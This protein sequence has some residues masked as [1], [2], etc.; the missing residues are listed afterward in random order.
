MKLTADQLEQLSGL[1]DTA[2]DL[3]QT[4]LEAWLGSLS[5][6]A[7]ALVPL[8]RDLLARRAARETGELLD[9]VPAFTVDAAVPASPQ[10]QAG[11]AVGPYRLQRELGRGGM[12]EVWLAERG[13]GQLKRAVA[14][15]LPIPNAR[16]SVLVQ[17]FAR[18]RDILGSLEHPHIARLYDA[19]FADDGQP[20]L[21]MEYVQGQ[22][23]DR[24]CKQ[25]LLGVPER[26]GLLLQVA[27]AV[28]FAHSRLVLHRDLKPSNILVTAEA[29][30]R[31]LD[32]GIAK[33]MQGETTRETELTLAAGRALTLDYA[34]P[35]QIRGAGIGTA[36][37][38]YS[39]GVVAFELLAG[40]RPYRLTRGSAAELEEA[41]TAQEPASASSMAETDALRKQLR[42]DI[43]AIL[44]KA[45]KKHPA[46]RYATIDALAQDWRR[47]LA[48][49]RVLARPDTWGLRLWRM[50][51]RHRL[52]LAAGALVVAAFVLGLGFGATALVM[53]ALVV[54]LAAALWQAGRARE[55]ARVARDESRR[56]QAVQGFLLDIFRANADTQ[57]DPAKAR[58]ATA[59]ELLDLGAQRL[60]TALHDTPQARAE[61]MATL[62]EMY[63][64]LG[65]D[66][67]AADLESQ[68]VELL[69]RLH[70]QDDRRVAQALV[71]LSFAL[72]TSS[73]RAEI[74]PALEEAKRILDAIGDRDSSL[75]GELLVRLAQ[76]NYSI[77]LSRS[78]AYAD[79]AVAVLR[80][81][82]DVG[83]DLHST[84]LGMSARV[85]Q[86]VG[87]L[88]VA[89]QLWRASIREIQGMPEVSQLQLVELRCSLADTLVLQLEVDA[90]LPIAREAV[91]TG[92]AAVGEADPV[93]LAARSRY[94]SVLHAAGQRVEARQEFE[95]SLQAILDIK[96]DADTFYTPDARLRY[97]RSLLAEGRL[98]QAQALVQAANATFRQH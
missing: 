9:R 62:A 44:N 4:E 41:I 50:G 23:L 61:V 52:P 8:L 79:E 34:S 45:L 10:F 78:M 82:P 46:E 7:L 64:L 21:A 6:E 91:E 5:G 42:G 83:R 94:A 20:Y 88:A 31:L 76:R 89:Q 74:L 49:Q 56:A 57:Q 22:P 92:S 35:E 48:G 24:Y 38:V 27:E 19:G 84:A 65:L 40:V 81:A 3:P 72:H 90:A 17:R 55:Q 66:D 30:V 98:G 69:R 75:R 93:V 70:G 68:R 95:A 36:S 26:L 63:L 96:G 25:H 54:G 77:S 67:R 71:H 32:F 86:M 37:D 39:L 97:A 14:L 51:R 13:D 15:K 33:L 80:A 59:R 53:L 1:L 16:R 85:H 2:L 11:E 73:R 60:A 47:H 18:E 12:G 43:D 58:E 87:D 28:A 29:Q